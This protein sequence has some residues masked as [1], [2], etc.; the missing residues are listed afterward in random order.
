MRRE[1][2]IKLRVLILFLALINFNALC[3]NESSLNDAVK[4]FNQIV[5]DEKS[6]SDKW[7]SSYFIMHKRVYGSSAYLKDFVF[8][9]GIASDNKAALLYKAFNVDE[10]LSTTYLLKMKV[11]NSIWEVQSIATYDL[12]SFEKNKHGLVE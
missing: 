9:T 3:N 5:T 12:E 6:L 1:R 10:K 2:F 4:R 7:S 8:L 11:E